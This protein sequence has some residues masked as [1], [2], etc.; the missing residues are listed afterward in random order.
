[1]SLT[2]LRPNA[3]YCGLGRLAL[4]QCTHP[5]QGPPRNS[6]RKR[7]IV[8]IGNAASSLH[9]YSVIGVA[10]GDTTKRES[11]LG[12]RSLRLGV[13]KARE[14]SLDLLG[15]QPTQGIPINYPRCSN[16]T[17]SKSYISACVCVYIYIHI[18]IYIYINVLIYLFI[19]TCD[20]NMLC[21]CMC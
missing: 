20:Y 2:S 1:M 17:L 10:S 15:P 16:Q 21:F 4:P 18:Y 3:I 13:C 5:A 11:C 6:T 12:F 19:L 8:G 14:E 9:K 7:E